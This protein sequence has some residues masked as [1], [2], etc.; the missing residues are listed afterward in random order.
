MKKRLRYAQGISL[1]EVL[2]SMLILS[3]GILGLAPLMV[4]STE[5]N[6]HSRDLSFATQLAKDQLET[7]EAADSIGSVPSITTEENVHDKFT[8][9]TY[10]GDNTSDSLIPENRYKVVVI[11]SWTDDMGSECSSQMSTII[12][13]E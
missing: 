13:K 7:L 10:I 3:F 11:I 1:L 8:R 5:S 12:K 6:S 4:L 9:T 2:I